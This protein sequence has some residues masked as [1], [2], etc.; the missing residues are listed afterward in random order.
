M[1]DKMVEK[2][3][4][5]VQMNDKELEFYTDVA[6]EL[7]ITRQSWFRWIMRVGLD[8]PDE[9][10]AH[11]LLIKIRDLGMTDVAPNNARTGPQ[12]SEDEAAFYRRLG[13]LADMPF[14]KVFKAVLR[15]STGYS[16]EAGGVVDYA[17]KR[18]RPIFKEEDV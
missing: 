7:G 9:K 12:F 4:I 11:A 18:L 2:N 13:H 1:K 14:S 16:L 6:N 10:K 8:F 15:H 17:L 3:K 5:V